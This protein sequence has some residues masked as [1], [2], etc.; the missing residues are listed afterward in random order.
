M[1][2]LQ[3]LHYKTNLFGNSEVCL[4]T[5]NLLRDLPNLVECYKV[6]FSRTMY[7]YKS[8][9]F[10]AVVAVAP[11]FVEGD[12][13]YSCYSEHVHHLPRNNDLGKSLGELAESLFSQVPQPS[14]RYSVRRWF[15]CFGNHKFFFNADG[16]IY[17]GVIIG[18]R[19]YQ[20]KVERPFSVLR[21]NSLK[22]VTAASKLLSETIASHYPKV[23]SH[24]DPHCVKINQA[25]DLKAFSKKFLASSAEFADMSKDFELQLSEID[26]QLKILTQKR[27]DL[28][29]EYGIK[30]RRM[31]REQMSQMEASHDCNKE[32]IISLR[33]RLDNASI[34]VWN[35]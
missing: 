24:F 4:N 30:T 34:G 8:L 22:I 20:D 25:S 2:N 28:G 12:L 11:I 18:G 32:Q 29:I 26:E 31:V 17:Y 35:F 16:R 19:G 1:A 33:K 27:R 6:E 10:H 3:F 21:I 13:N 7:N 14:P 9:P 15:N 23:A 5:D